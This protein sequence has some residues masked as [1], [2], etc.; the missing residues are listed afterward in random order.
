MASLL[1]VDY[2]RV[3]LW[4]FARLAAEPRTDWDD[5]GTALARVIGTRKT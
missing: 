1:E 5:D 3:K 4:M 2:E